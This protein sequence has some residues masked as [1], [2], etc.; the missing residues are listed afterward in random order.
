M[1]ERVGQYWHRFITQAAQTSFPQARLELP[2]VKG[3]LGVYFRAMGGDAGLTISSCSATLHNARRSWLHRLAGTGQK[4]ELAWRDERCLYLPHSLDVL[5]SKTLNRDLYYWLAALASSGNHLSDDWL[6]TSQQTTLKTLVAFPGLAARY[7]QLV[8]AMLPLRPSLKSLSEA[9]KHQE[10]TI[11]Q[12]L[13]K[14]GSVAAGTFFQAPRPPAPVYLWLH[15]SPPLAVV[16]LGVNEGATAGLGEVKKIAQAD[17]R[18]R[19]GERVEMPDDKP[20]APFGVRHETSLFSFAEYVKLDRSAE[21]DEDLSDAEKIADELDQMALAQSQTSTAS[22][23]KF[24]L[25][26]PSAAADDLVLSEG[27]RY[28]EWDYSKQQLQA[29]YCQLLPMLSREAKAC[30]LPEHLRKP[31]TALKRQ[32]QQLAAFPRWHKG[33]L[34]GDR[35]DIEAYVDY[36]ASLQQGQQP[37]EARL[38]SQKR[39]AARDLTTLLLADLSLSTDAW[40]N[41]EQQVIDVIRDSLFVFAESLKAAGDQFAMHGFSSCKRNHVRMHCIKNFSENYNAH[42]RGRIAAIKPGFYTRMGAAIRHATALLERQPE[43]KKLLLI[44][45]D[46]KP[47]DLDRYEGRYGIEDTRMAIVEAKKMGLVP[48]C[49]TIDSRANQYLPYLFGHQGYSWISSAR[50][51]PKKLPQL[52]LSLTQRLG[53]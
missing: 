14:P 5:P 45:T 26:L 1:E 9:E 17:E 21:E 43:E 34:E 44:V 16:D 29:N 6:H 18:R 32:F 37:A 52:Y 12:A 23:I 30:E 33:Q 15:P 28:P 41:D 25:D 19:R 2:A 11:R 51:L 3:A 7:E 40:V 27:I 35:L 47:N 49:I 53:P 36:W 42:I 31:C 39:P 22:R 8:A 50:Q 10:L 48:Y 4:V 24:D 13:S 46:G 20:G 38:F